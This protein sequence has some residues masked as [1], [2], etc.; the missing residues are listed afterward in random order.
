MERRVL[1]KDID[2]KL[3]GD[4]RVNVDTCFLVFIQGV[5]R[6]ITISAPVF[7]FAISVQARTISAIVWSE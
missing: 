3:T 5:F 4:N 7:T 6:S 1:L 2:K